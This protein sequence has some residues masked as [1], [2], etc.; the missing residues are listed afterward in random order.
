VEFRLRPFSEL[1]RAEKESADTLDRIAFA[2]DP[3]NWEW[4]TPDWLIQAFEMGQL[5]SQ[6]AV[7]DR[8]GLLDGQ[9]IHLGG[10]GGVATLPEFR[11]RG[12]AAA[13]LQEADKFICDSLMVDFGLL[14]C[15]EK[16][17]R[18]YGKFGWKVI[19]GP[20]L[21]DQPGGKFTYQEITM[22][23][24]CQQK[25]WPGGTVDLCGLPW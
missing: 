5:V 20:L 21:F 9:S 3:S 6:L 24:P 10:I 1:T 7:I 4:S 16:M 14:V 11:K 15:N 2:N 23:L 12:F 13:V 19:T 22:V 17:S 25:N 8:I 18:Y